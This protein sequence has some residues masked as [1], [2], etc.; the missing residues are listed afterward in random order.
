M[1]DK[2]KGF[3]FLSLLAFGVSFGV[4]Y[5][6]ALDKVVYFVVDGDKVLVEIYGDKVVLAKIKDEDGISKL[7]G[8]VEILSLGGYELKGELRRLGKL[9]AIKAL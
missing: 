7:T 1:L 2:I 5:R 4:G 6:L 3:I 9:K 8:Q